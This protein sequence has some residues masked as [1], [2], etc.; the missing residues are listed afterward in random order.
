MYY[1]QNNS[2]IAQNTTFGYNYGYNYGPTDRKE[3]I[4]SPL[5]LVYRCGNGIDGSTRMDSVQ[6]DGK[7][8]DRGHA[9]PD[10][11]QRD[12][13]TVRRLRAAERTG[14][15]YPGGADFPGGGWH[16]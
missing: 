9:R 10:D 5:R 2:I 11:K 7:H 14:G 1:S 12:L 15:A 4:P 16:S 8:N 3:N 6:F 13:R